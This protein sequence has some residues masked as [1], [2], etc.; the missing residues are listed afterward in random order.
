[1]ESET[2]IEDQAVTLRHVLRT[3]SAAGRGE[4]DAQ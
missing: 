1:M 3:D 4:V 2:R